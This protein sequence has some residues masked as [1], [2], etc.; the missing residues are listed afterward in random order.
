MPH[1]TDQI[2][3]LALIVGLVLTARAAAAELHGGLRVSAASTLLPSMLRGN[4][5]DFDITLS[6]RRRPAGEPDEDAAQAALVATAREV[7]R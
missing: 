5:F 1:I 3:F 2:L 4:P 6:E 7:Q